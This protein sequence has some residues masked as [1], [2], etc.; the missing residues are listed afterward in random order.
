MLL[1][2]IRS[3]YI[4]IL[5]S[6]GV[7]TKTIV[8]NLVYARFFISNLILF[9]G[10]LFISPKNVVTLASYRHQSVNRHSNRRV[11]PRC[12]IPLCAHSFLYIH[13]YILIIIE[14]TCRIYHNNTHTWRRNRDDSDELPGRLYYIHRSIAT[15]DA[16]AGKTR[17]H[18]PPEKRFIPPLYFII[19]FYYYCRCVFFIIIII[20]LLLISIQL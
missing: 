9:L 5:Y 7:G 17:T 13:T 15:A 10:F 3:K 6:A 12:V 20:I 18:N 4:I 16:A 8:S 2:N 14:N 1:Y 19:L 11:T